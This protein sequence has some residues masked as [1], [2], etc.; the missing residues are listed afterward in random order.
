MVAE[1]MYRPPLVKAPRALADLM[2]RCWSQDPALRP[3]FNEICAELDAVGRDN[4]GVD[5]LFPFE[6]AN[7]VNYAADHIVS[8]L[9]P[10]PYSKGG[11]YRTPRE[12]E[13]GEAVAGSMRDS[14]IPPISPNSLRIYEAARSNTS[15]KL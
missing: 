15:N 8:P 14:L 5:S 7:L 10:T 1:K 9:P 11:G 3:S 13:A 12:S 6:I 4:A 2:Q